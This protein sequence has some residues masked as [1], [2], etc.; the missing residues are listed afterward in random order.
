MDYGENWGGAVK[1][2]QDLLKWL[3]EEGATSMK[4]STVSI[5]QYE[6]KIMD[7][8]NVS[9]RQAS[10]HEES[11]WIKSKKGQ[12]DSKVWLE[13]VPEKESSSEVRGAIVD[14]EFKDKYMEIIKKYSNPK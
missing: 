2:D 14:I 13:F 5:K 9:E 11:G 4:T 10:R 8:S 12:H 1:K 7:L 3:H 6:E